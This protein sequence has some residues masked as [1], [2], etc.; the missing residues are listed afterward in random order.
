MNAFKAKVYLKSLQRNW[1]FF[2]LVVFVTGFYWAPTTKSLNNI[3]YVLLLLPLVVTFFFVENK[4]ANIK[5]FI[6]NYKYF[7]IFSLLMLVSTMWNAFDQDA[8]ANNVKRILYVVGFLLVINISVEKIDTV[9]EKILPY[10]LL[11]ASLSAIYKLFFW[12]STYTV[13]HR[14]EGIGITANSILLAIIYSVAGLVSLMV[15]LKG[16]DKKS[17]VF[18]AA[19]LICFAV[20]VLGQSRGPLLSLGFSICLSLILFRGN[21]ALFSM[22]ALFVTVT[23]FA[24]QYGDSRVF[25]LYDIRIDI[26]KAAL[27]TISTSPLLGFGLQTD[28]AVQVGATT[29]HHPHSVYITTLFHGGILGLMALM[30][31]IASVLSADIKNINLLPWRVLLCLGLVYMLFDGYRVFSHPEEIWLIF[32]LPIG[33]L[34]A[35]TTPKIAW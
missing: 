16:T 14:M 33:V 8:C 12:L 3:F 1:F 11:A 28:E 31:M 2:A 18:L 4:L 22:A 35:R 26:W 9:G 27:E 7:F 6:V 23:F 20:V 29:F 24:T 34:M 25:S 17:W 13:H 19:A 32:W 15:F 21:R 10:A 5:I 30:A